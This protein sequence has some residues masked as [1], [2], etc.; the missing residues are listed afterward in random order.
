MISHTP[1]IQRHLGPNSEEKQHLLDFLGLKDSKEF[2]D[3]VIP[4]SLR[5]SHRLEDH[6]GP[7]L[8]EFEALKKLKN[9][10]NQNRLCENYIGMGFYDTVTPPVIQRHVLE[11]PAWYTAYTPYQA[12]ISQGRLESL[13]NFQTLV[14]DLTGMDLANASMLDEGSAC[15]EA[16]NMT[17]HSSFPSSF[18]DKGGHTKIT[19]TAS[20]S[21]ESAKTLS[22]AS[23]ISTVLLDEGLH[24]HIIEVCRTRMVALGVRVLLQSPQNFDF[25][26]KPKACVLAYP[27]TRGEI[28]DYAKLTEKAHDSHCFVIV[29]TDLLALTLLTPP[30]EWGADVVVGN[31]QRLGVPLGNGGPHA[32][33]L[34]TRESFKRQ[35]PGRLIGVSVDQEGRKAYRLTL[36]TREQ[37]IRRE[38]ATSNICTSQVLLANMAAM[39]AVYHGPKGLKKIAT[40]IHK[41]TQVAATGLE[42]LGLPAKNTDFFDT[43]Y[44]PTTQA[45]ALSL[46][47]E[48]KNI[49]IRVFSE[50]SQACALGFSFNETTT[51]ENIIQLLCYL[52]EALNVTPLS[53]DLLQKTYQSV[54]Y[55]LNLP[56][57]LSRKSEYLNHPVFH[58]YHSE[59]EMLRYITRLQNKDI[60]LAQSMIP[61]GSCTMKLNATS[62]LL[63]LAW[64]EVS[65]IH[66]FAP[67]HQMQGYLEMMKDLEFKLC[68]ITGFSHISFQPNSGAQGEYAGLLVIKKYFESIGQSHRHICLTPSSAHGTNPASA[69]LAGFKV[70]VVSCD[71]QGNIDLEDLKA[72]AF[73]H[74][75]ALGAL[76]ITYPSTHGVFEESIQEVCRTIH[77]CGGQVYM[78]GAN[79]NS[80]VG[81]VRPSEIGA[82]VSHMNLHKTFA[83]PHGGGGPGV[84]PIGVKPHLAAFLPSHPLQPSVNA[85]STSL[86]CLTSG[87]WGSASILTISWMYVTMM[88]G[89]GLKEAT[90]TAILNANY[91]AK[92]L[93]QDFSILYRG[94]NNKV[95]HE[96][97]L[98]F[99]PFKSL[100]IEV[101]DIAKRLMDFGFHSPTMSWPVTGTL[102]IEPTESENKKELD[103]FILAMKQIRLEISKIQEGLWPQDNNPLKNAPHTM[104][105]V[106]S[107]HWSHPYT[108]EEAAFALPWLENQKYWTPVSRINDAFGDR[109]IVCL[110][111]PLE[112]YQN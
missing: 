80:L 18:S 90:Y 52:A 79:L 61:L 68:E 76:M 86:G 70:V 51:L 53:P 64:P 46:Y 88:G 111:P 38:K 32:A 27:N 85:E 30:G 104:T 92:Q 21:S 47:L 58:L 50:N 28:H 36:Q 93:E 107:S 81:W 19:K 110:C 97:I 45:K 83:I 39:Y 40:E 25:S 48:S 62:E 108:R 22:T 109:H 101:V 67:I 6:L 98:D 94:Q 37:H 26:L 71:S 14:S 15:A 17:L 49:N 69:V 63:P 34:A 57:K 8:S 84:G 12:E 23:T 44:V 65:Q 59:T 99:R 9:M 103:R 16:L 5:T 24:P 35:I 78:D 1:F 105:H 54:C 3:Q 2:L 60:T 33:F 66:P 13:L 102:M 87:P 112:D 95:A 73:L 106:C 72:K 77:E 96:C 4:S 82:D 100:G 55:H 41:I 31:S 10:M 11:N 89:S 91:L 29:N 56:Q 7:G 42:L 43:L 20:Q 75:E 74:R